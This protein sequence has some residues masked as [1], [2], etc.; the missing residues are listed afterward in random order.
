MRILLFTDNHFCTNSSI[1]RQL[2]NY[3]SLRLENQIQ[4]INWVEKLAINKNCDIVCCLG[5][6]FDKP[7]LNDQELTALKA[8]TWNNLPHY[9]LV[10]NHESSEANLSFSSTKILEAQNI[11]IIDTPLIMEL[12][13]VEI[14]FLPYISE[15][16]RQPIQDYFNFKTNKPR[17]IFS[18]NDLCGVQM[19]PVISKV[20]FSLSEIE[21]ICDLF[22]NGHL[23]NGQKITNKILNLGN[24][25]GKDF[26]EDA[27]K[28]PH[29][30]IIIDTES[31]SC[32]F[33]ENPYAFNFYKLDI[34]DKSSINKLYSL[35]NN[36]VVSIK[37]LDSLL[38]EVK[39]AVKAIP[40]IIDSRIIIT[41]AS[42]STEP[43]ADILDLSLD[44]IA[45]FIECC[46]ENIEN[47]AILDQELSEI[48]K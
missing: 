14:G 41:R 9:F 15:S 28:Y 5:D 18:H 4:S 38:A 3:F 24:L 20:G 36:A 29:N 19:G 10:G 33:I 25:T 35:K 16:D 46:K 12:P 40:T 39:E 6:F 7:E 22:I 26:G 31:F 43:T 37:C 1:I 13:D 47:T 11:K 30:I 2:G 44:H 27:L 17:L 21:D 23:H 8:I 48:C 42:L 32:E 45:K 34:T